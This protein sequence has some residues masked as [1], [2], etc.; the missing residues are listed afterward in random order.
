MP[1][2]DA[3]ARNGRVRADGKMVHDMLLVQVKA[4]EDSKYPWDYYQVVKVV[5][6]DQAFMPLSESKCPLLK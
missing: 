4:N 6:G 5:P 1:I 3:F 2:E